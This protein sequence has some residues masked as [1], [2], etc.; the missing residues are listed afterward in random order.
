MKKYDLK[1]KIEP[2]DVGGPPFL[3]SSSSTEISKTGSED[4]QWS[5][6][7]RVAVSRVEEQLPADQLIIAP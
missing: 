4:N 6:V 7:E 5:E 2:P 3:G 1:K